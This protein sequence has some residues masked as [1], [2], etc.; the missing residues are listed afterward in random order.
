[1]NSPS[2]ILGSSSVNRQALLSRLRIEFS[3]RSPN[4]DESP[5]AGESPVMTAQRLASLKADSVRTMIFSES[6][7]A[8]NQRAIIITSDQV[9]FRAGAQDSS[10]IFDKPL[11][12]ARAIAQLTNMQGQ[13]IAFF[14][15]LEVR[16][17]NIARQ[18]TLRTLTGG[19]MTYAVFRSLTAQQIERYVDLDDP[20]QCAGAA[21]C[22]SLGIALLSQVQSDDPTALIGLPLILLT[23]FL[24]SLE[25]PII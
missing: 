1:M 25:V 18:T 8:E 9:A 17:I 14:T 19:V 5:L 4:V 12:R 10:A 2:I 24:T 15:S 21:K 7:N 3:T 20:L 11:T 23:D 13:A 22:E 16:E 6:A